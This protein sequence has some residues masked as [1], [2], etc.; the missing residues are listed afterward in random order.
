[1]DAGDGEEHRDEKSYGGGDQHEECDGRDEVRHLL[2][3][4]TAPLEQERVVSRVP[5]EGVEDFAEGGKAL[6]REE[7]VHFPMRSWVDRRWTAR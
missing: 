4:E 3:Q 6:A 7:E 2:V 5:G 1:M